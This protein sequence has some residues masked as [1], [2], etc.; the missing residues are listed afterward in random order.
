MLTLC[1][2]FDLIKII[3]NSWALQTALKTSNDQDTSKHFKFQLIIFSCVK[4]LLCG[5]LWFNK[6]LLN[7]A[8]LQLFFVQAAG[9]GSK[10]P[11]VIC[12]FL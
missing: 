7:L 9:G 3:F 6:S 8:L 11:L 5:V 4:M 2:L 10:K 12:G 1:I